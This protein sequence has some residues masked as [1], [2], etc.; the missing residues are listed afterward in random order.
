MGRPKALKKDDIGGHWWPPMVAN[1]DID[2]Q[3]L[4]GM[5]LV[6]IGGR[7]WWPTSALMCNN[8]KG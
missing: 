4:Q 6:A 8:C 1:I 5:T 2:V 3:Q 7:K